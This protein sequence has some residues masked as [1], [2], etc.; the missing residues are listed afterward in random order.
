MR[1]SETKVVQLVESIPPQLVVVD[2]IS[3]DEISF[4]PVEFDRLK[5]AM[6]YFHPYIHKMFSRE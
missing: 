6:D 5:T 4:S 2:E 3:G 1:I